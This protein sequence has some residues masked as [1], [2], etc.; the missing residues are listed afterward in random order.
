[1]S[2]AGVLWV[3]L[4]THMKSCSSSHI[5]GFRLSKTFCS[6]PFC[7]T[8]GYLNLFLFCV[9]GELYAGITSDFMS[10]DS[11]FFRSLGSRH[12]IRTEQYDSTWLRGR[13]NKTSKRN[14][15][16][17]SL[18]KE[19]LHYKKDFKKSAFLIQKTTNKKTLHTVY[20]T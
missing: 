3:F 13:C 19:F 6:K 1:M 15:N 4:G 12:V 20:A 17:K 9:D 16:K 18:K 14:N 10:R 11:A 7:L 8:E 5:L 2:A